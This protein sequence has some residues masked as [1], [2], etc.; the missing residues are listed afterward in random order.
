MRPAKPI[1][2]LAAMLSAA[3]CASAPLTLNDNIIVPGERVGDVELGMTLAQLLNLKGVP[4]KTVPI[5]G[6][7]ATTY[8]F[9][10]LTVAADDKVYWI[11]AKN[12][13]F[14]TIKGVT[15]GSEQIYARASFGQPECVVTRASSTSYD[16]GNLYFDVDN[17][18]GR[19][20]QLGIQENTQTCDQ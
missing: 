1:A 8:F 14:R 19:V 15:V 12:P 9:D 3:A 2:F 7:A 20:T 5:P 11:I 6:T 13:R 16:Y 4:I 17:D 10:G 18:T